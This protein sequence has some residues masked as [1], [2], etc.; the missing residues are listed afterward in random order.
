[1]AKNDTEKA[2]RKKLKAKQKRFVEEYL[3]DLNATAAAERAGYKYPNMA[4]PRLMVNDG[5]AQ[6]I[7]TAMAER[8]VRTQITIDKVVTM[9]LEH[10]E[11]C[12]AA[13]EFSA[14]NKPLELLGRH[15]G[16]FPN[17]VEVGGSLDMEITCVDDSDDD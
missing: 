11:R 15:V 6:A 5:I 12:V 10:Y 7:K 9:A 1:M 17:K 4:G 2:K 3:K 14:A 16:A 8:S 13:G